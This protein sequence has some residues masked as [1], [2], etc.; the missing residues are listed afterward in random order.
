MGFFILPAFFNT[1]LVFLL[2]VAGE[3]LVINACGLVSLLF[4]FNSFLGGSRR[5]VDVSPILA[6]T[7][8]DSRPKNETKPSNAGRQ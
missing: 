7:G 6:R 4:L 8:S 3:R 1:M 5:A 2:M